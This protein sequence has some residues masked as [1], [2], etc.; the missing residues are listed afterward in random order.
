MS[1]KHL[2]VEV[3]ERAQLNLFPQ[4]E[5]LTSIELIVAGLLETARSPSGLGS[6]DE[7][8]ESLFIKGMNEQIRK[9]SENYPIINEVR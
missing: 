6:M 9:L 8:R 7:S 5:K 2:R 1:T 3:S 4:G